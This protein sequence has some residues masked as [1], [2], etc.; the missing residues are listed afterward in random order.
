MHIITGFQSDTFI[1]IAIQKLIDSGVDE[2]NIVIVEMKNH[3]QTEN[4]F[5]SKSHFDGVSL[6]D[7][8]ASWS[9]VGALIG[10]IWGSQIKIGPL[11][12]GLI[13]FMITAFIGYLIDK[14]FKK[15]KKSKKYR[16][17]I[18]VLL[19]VRCSSREQIRMAESIFKNSHARSIGFHIPSETGT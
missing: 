18:D 5:D 13:G 2:K 17:Y 11:A 9:V 19:I 6:L 4:L 10:I 12:A 3:V 15:R 8:I 16:N 1:E 7:G 14:G